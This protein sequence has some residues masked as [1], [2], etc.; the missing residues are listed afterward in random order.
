MQLVI[1]ESPY[2][3]DNLDK[4]RENVLYARE[5]IKDSISRGEA[6]F[7]SHLLYTQEGILNDMNA[8]ERAKGIELGFNWLLKADLVT[9]YIDRGISVGM[10]KGMRAALEFNIPIEIRA[11][12]H[13]TL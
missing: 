1:V 8:D 4:R 9:V 5:C 11:L 12:N 3:S 6:P 2:R 10:I 13:N 7:A